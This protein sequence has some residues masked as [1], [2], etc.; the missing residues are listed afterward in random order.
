[1]PTFRRA[2]V[3]VI[4]FAVASLTSA[5]SQGDVIGPNVFISA[6]NC[7]ADGNAIP[8]LE[9][10]KDRELLTKP[11]DAHGEVIGQGVIRF[12]VMLPAGL[13]VVKLIGGHSCIALDDV[14]VLPG[15]VRHVVFL[16]RPS[17][18]LIDKSR[19]IAGE[20]PNAGLAVSAVFSGGR[21]IPAVVEDGAYYI[22]HLDAKPYTVRF[23]LTQESYVDVPVNTEGQLTIYNLGLEDLRK[24][25]ST[26]R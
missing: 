2:I 16:L 1:M 23:K 25:A 5:T 9:V 26:P 13:N 22:N 14:A 21:A 3:A 11:F 20:I 4:V 8:R 19:V 12:G 10:A 6:L 18:I 15:H 17:L 24:A 7:A